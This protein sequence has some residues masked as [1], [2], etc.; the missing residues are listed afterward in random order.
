MIKYHTSIADN[1]ST[2]NS[3][4]HK[5]PNDGTP[6]AQLVSDAPC[7]L[8]NSLYHERTRAHSA[9]MVNHL[10]LSISRVSDRYGAFRIQETQETFGPYLQH[11]PKA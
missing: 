8:I 1:K 7:Y 3:K 11:V 10:E 5:R 9:Q 4:V 6:I 2:L